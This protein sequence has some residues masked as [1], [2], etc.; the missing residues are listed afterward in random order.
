MSRKRTSQYVALF[1]YS[2][3]G[4]FLNDTMARKTDLYNENDKK[5]SHRN[6]HTDQSPDTCVRDFKHGTSGKNSVQRI[7]N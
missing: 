3:L 7:R 6:R 1:L 5:K 2:A 4:V